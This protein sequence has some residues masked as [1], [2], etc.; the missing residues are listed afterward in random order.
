MWNRQAGGDAEGPPVPRGAF[1]PGCRPR[2]GRGGRLSESA[3]G[4]MRGEE[5]QQQI[6]P[7]VPENRSG[8]A[9]NIPSVVVSACRLRSRR[10]DVFLAANL[11]QE[12]VEEGRLAGSVGCATDFGSGRDVAVREFEPRVGLCADGSESGSRFGFCVSLSL[13]SSPTRTLSCCLSEIN[14]E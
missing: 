6:L 11:S 10:R 14:K 3:T 13:C 9:Q 1:D 12:S 8:A 4:Q 2:G 5:A 7:F